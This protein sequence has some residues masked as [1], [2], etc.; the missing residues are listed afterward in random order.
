MA[1]ITTRQTS[2]TGATVKGTPLSNAELDNNFINLNNAVRITRANVNIT[3]GGTIT[4]N[5]SY[6]VLWTSRFIVIS[7]G[8]SSSTAVAGFWDISC[9]TSGT[10][11]GVGGATNKTATASGIPLDV[12]DA[13][14]YI[15]PLGSTNTSLAANFRVVNYTADVEVPSNWVLICVRNGDNG[16]VHFTAGFNLN[17]NDS[18][19]GY[20]THANTAN[21]VVSRDGSGN[22]S[23]GTI[24]AALSGNASTATTL[25]TARTLTIGS[26]GKTFNG[27][28]DVT[29][30]FTELGVPPL[31]GGSTFTGPGSF[32]AFSIRTSDASALNW[33]W[34]ALGGTSDSAGNVWHIATNG[35]AQDIGA[36]GAL[37]L[38]GSNGGQTSLA[39]NQ[40][41]SVRFRSADVQLNTNQVL[42]AGNYTNYS[43]TLTGGSASGTWGIS[44][45]GSA[46]TLTTTRTLWGQN[47]NGS[48][49]V[50]GN[51]TS[52]GSITLNGG[53][54]NNILI[55]SSEAATVAST[56]QTQV[57][58][59]ASASFRSAKLVV[60]IYDSVTGEVQISELLVA[61]NGTTAQATEYGVVFTG[62]QALVT[63][64][65]DI[66]GGNVRLLA[67][68]TTANSTQYKV[69]ETLM[70]A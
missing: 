12:W 64:D 22:F 20:E 35:T 48:A 11:T 33:S 16:V 10:I 57:A 58:S 23:A 50:T 55:F 29:W 4:V 7:N 9:P 6:N 59:F 13:L 15:L 34:F 28:A 39:I 62:N 61:H 60:Q 37:H 19:L 41:H 24:T 2:G 30:T 63:F 40:D 66:S 32:R 8:R 17:A 56:T 67:T 25:Q 38:R 69:S 1:Q 43:P 51:L 21:T 44:I 65:V 46:P 5:N 45:T 54:A 47:F 52:V 49:N 68:R 53:T 14:Y 18:T 42:H 27:S 36:A 26:T 3:G 31:G 70:V